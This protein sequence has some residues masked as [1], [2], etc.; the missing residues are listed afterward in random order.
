[1]TYETHR[2]KKTKSCEDVFCCT[3]PYRKLQF[4]YFV[5]KITLRGG[6]RNRFLGQLFHTDR[7]VRHPRFNL[8]YE[9][10]VAVLRTVERLVEENNLIRP[11]ALGL[12]G[13]ITEDE[14]LLNVTG[15]GMTEVRLYIWHIMKSGNF[16]PFICHFLAHS[17][18][19]IWESKNGDGAVHE[20]QCLQWDFKRFW[21]G[22]WN[23]RKCYRRVKKQ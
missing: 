20:L 19:S 7:I 8:D 15:W 18:K 2:W 14:S 4:F 10:D 6:H 1:M 12:Q 21:R 13:T 9:Y 5:L 16:I 17:Y 3:A 23:V 22:H 11:V